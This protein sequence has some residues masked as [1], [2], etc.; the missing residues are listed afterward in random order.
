M[1]LDSLWQS[2]V[3]LG[4]TWGIRIIGV[5]VALVLAFLISGWLRRAL[6]RSLE[7]RNF[8][9]TLT[10]FFGAL[11]RYAILVAAIIGCLGVFGIQTASFAAAIAAIG[12]AVGLALQGTLSNFAAGVML[13]IFRPFNVGE[14]IRVAGQ[15]GTV[16]ALQLFTT[17]LKTLDNRKLVVPN[18]Q[19]FGAVIENLTCHPTRRVDIPVGVTYSADVDET[20]R[21][22]EQ[23]PAK[24]EQVLPDPPPQIFLHQ[25]GASSVD[26]QVRVWCKTEDYWD[27]HQ[28]VVRSTKQALDEAG[29]SIPFPQ[30][31]VHLD[32]AVA[33]ALG[34]RRL[35]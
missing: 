19:I 10:R 4:A 12:L 18:S 14:L 6:I 30:M 24:V 2:L 15:L 35:V 23:V 32:P 27:V 20:R 9:L 3:N 11:V 21:V 17:D 29:L 22:L 7:R 25:L 28:A 31:D 33:S 8:D 5:V 16:D 13:L 26:W 1:D 34:G